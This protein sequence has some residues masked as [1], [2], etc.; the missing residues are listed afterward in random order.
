MKVESGYRSYLCHLL[1]VCGQDVRTLCLTFLI[2]KMGL[3]IGEDYRTNMSADIQQA[4]R[5]VSCF[6]VVLNI[7]QLGTWLSLWI[8]SS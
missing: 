2:F 7:V 5:L 3:K 6:V 1:A 8:D 4:L